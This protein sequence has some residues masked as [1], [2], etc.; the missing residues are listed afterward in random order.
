M[1]G[2]V[3]LLSNIKQYVYNA[4]EANQFHILLTAVA[5]LVLFIQRCFSIVYH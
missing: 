1:L 2:F 4:F 5:A 3:W